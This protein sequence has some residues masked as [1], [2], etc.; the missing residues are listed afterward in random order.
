MTAT[1]MLPL[2]LRVN[3][4][5]IRSK[6]LF[7]FLDAVMTARLRPQRGLVAHAQAALD[8]KLSKY[9]K[10]GSSVNV[11]DALIPG[12]IERASKSL[13]DLSKLPFVNEQAELM[14]YGSG[15]TVFLLSRRNGDKVIKIYRRSLGLH[16]DSLLRITDEFRQKFNRVRSWYNGRFNL[17][18]PTEYLILHGPLLKSPATACVQPYIRGE[19]KDFFQDCSDNELLDLLKGN[20]RLQAQFIFFAEQTLCLYRRHQLFVDFIGKE[21]LMLVKEGDDHSLLVIDY[22]IFHLEKLEKEVPVTFSQVQTF[23]YRLESLLEALTGQA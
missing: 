1:S 5:H 16:I 20:N 23:I 2:K 14:A 17:V 22:G 3:A 6:L 7:K 19:K 12:T 9:E 8:P 13:C 10:F 15:S 21:N 11:M 18:L 4:E